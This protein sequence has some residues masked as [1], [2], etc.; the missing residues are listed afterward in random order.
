MGTGGEPMAEQK[1][2]TVSEAAEYLGVHI[3]TVRAWADKGWIPSVRWP[4][5]WRYF[6]Q[7]DLDETRVKL[8]L[9]PMG[10][11]AAAA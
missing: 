5:G 3:K 7:E 9:S 11:T 6:R 8:G 1:L 4:N 10:K 2:L